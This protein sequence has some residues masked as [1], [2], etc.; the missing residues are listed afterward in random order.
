MDKIDIEQELED[1]VKDKTESSCF[2]THNDTHF[3]PKV[4]ANFRKNTLKKSRCLAATKNSWAL[5]RLIVFFYSDHSS[6]AFE[7]LGNASQEMQFFHCFFEAR[8]FFVDFSVQHWV[9]AHA[10][11][12]SFWVVVCWRGVI[13]CWLIQR[14]NPSSRRKEK[15]SKTEKILLARLV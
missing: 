6:V 2:F 5:G 4:P 10:F 3:L 1:S 13:V 7:V 11:S 14:A 15:A 8:D 9:F 12:A